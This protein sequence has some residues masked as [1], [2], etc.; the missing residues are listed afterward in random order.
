ME[1]K[2]LL[3]FLKKPEYKEN[4]NPSISYRVRTTGILLIWALAISLSLAIALGIL[5]A[6]GPW[7]LDD[8]AF[9]VL[10]ESYSSLTILLLAA[11]VAPI[12]EELVFRGPLWFF[13]DSTY[14]PV[15]FYAGALAF[16]LVHL[17]N[18]PNLTEIWPVSPLLISPQFT[19]GLFLG[20]IR[21]RF[22]LI[23][24]IGFHAAYNTI[25]LAPMLVLNE[26]GISIS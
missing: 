12:L 6:V 17:S 14:F 5:G 9:E 11:L 15:I 18:F 20:F 22:G 3:E 4:S 25:L 7:N 8:H 1:I 10:L 26:L 21:I 24:C 16:S 13:R 2:E 19:L 23:W